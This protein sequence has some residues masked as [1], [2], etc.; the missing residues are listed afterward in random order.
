MKLGKDREDFIARF[1]DSVE[2][3]STLCIELQKQFME[4]S[5]LWW[6]VLPPVSDSLGF[7]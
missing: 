7:Q 6:L 5:R 3:S 1:K 4:V 2:K